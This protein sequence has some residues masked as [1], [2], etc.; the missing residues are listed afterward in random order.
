MRLWA[1]ESPSTRPWRTKEA[2]ETNVVKE[3]VLAWKENVYANAGRDEDFSILV[4]ASQR[5]FD[6]GEGRRWRLRF[7]GPGNRNP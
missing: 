1:V 2:N 7:G 3:G 4:E 5:I 6:V